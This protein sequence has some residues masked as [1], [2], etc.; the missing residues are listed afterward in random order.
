MRFSYS[1]SFLSAIAISVCLSLTGCTKSTN[2]QVNAATEPDVASTNGK[3]ESAEVTKVKKIDG[4]DFDGPLDDNKDAIELLKACNSSHV[5][6][7]KVE[8]L[9]SMGVD[10]NKRYQVGKHLYTPLGVLCKQKD[11]DEE[12]VRLLINHGA[13]INQPGEDDHAPLIITIN[14][15]DIDITALKLLIESGADVNIEDKDYQMQPLIYLLY[16]HWEDVSEAARLLLD[17]GADIN[18]KPNGMT[19]LMIA[20][21]QNVAK[22]LIDRGVDIHAESQGFNALYTASL[23]GNLE[24]VKYLVE[25]GLDPSAANK[26]GKTPLMY[27]GSIEVAKYLMEHGAVISNNQNYDTA[28][29][30]EFLQRFT[31]KDSTITP[32]TNE[33]IRDLSYLILYFLENGAETDRYSPPLSELA[34]LLKFDNEMDYTKFYNLYINEKTV[35]SKGYIDQSII[36]DTLTSKE[37]NGFKLTPSL[38]NVQHLMDLIEKSDCSVTS[39]EILAYLEN[40]KVDHDPKII[41]MLLNHSSE[42]SR[43]LSSYIKD[44]RYYIDEEYTIP[45]PEII[46]MLLD[47]GI[48]ADSYALS[49]YLT[50]PEHT[51]DIEI[52]KL[53]LP[54]GTVHDNVLHKY[55]NNSHLIPQNQII[56]ALLD[57][58]VPMYG[59]EFLNYLGNPEIEFDKKV[60]LRIHDASVTSDYGINYWDNYQ[61][62]NKSCVENIPLMILIAKKLPELLPQI[63]SSEYNANLSVTRHCIFS[64]ETPLM[65]VVSNPELVKLLIDAGADVNAVTSKGETALSR[66]IKGGFT[67]SAE[68]LKNAGASESPKSSDSF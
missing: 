15:K 19:A 13:D 6:L 66:A 49:R 59:D 58:E 52:V 17:A 50:A 55:L 21:H 3:P 30:T 46:H 63:D 16:N 20:R 34:S 40:D 57:A 29:M 68:L 9:I 47:N 26:K 60:A 48:K 36:Y 18:H 67:Q 4:V 45:K 51:P 56:E 10:L 64:D 22:L 28:F 27:A 5:D 62:I 12:A 42:G 1:Y 35:C 39:N 31:H 43:N 54:S 38:A 53:L 2:T 32:L 14:H 23:Y 44:P 37:Y 65:T 24:I 7:S 33:E 8:N 41:E 11:I 25:N 61:L